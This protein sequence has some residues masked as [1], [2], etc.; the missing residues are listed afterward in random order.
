[1]EHSKAK[2]RVICNPESSGGGYDPEELHGELEGYE[3]E[4]ITTE[5]PGDA[6]KAAKEWREGLL[7]VVGG[8]G[9]IS[10]VV[11]GL[12]QAGFPEG[13]TLALLPSGT[14][15]DLAATLA[16]PENPDEAGDVIRQGKVRT[17]DAAR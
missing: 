2:T 16:V 6:R 17:L 8:D 13:V 1:M 14:G 4:W 11:N 9:T 15:N 12:G 10:E 3:L 7:I 5:S